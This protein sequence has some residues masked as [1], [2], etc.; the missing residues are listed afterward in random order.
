MSV[1]DR[2]RLGWETHL[3]TLVI[4]LVVV[5]AVLA[6]TYWLLVL[7]LR[8]KDILA[9]K[10]RAHY[11]AANELLSTYWKPIGAHKAEFFCRQTI[12]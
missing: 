10:F 1:L 4:A 6:A 9:S 3:G 2:L 7:R 12:V 5:L 8:R 11:E